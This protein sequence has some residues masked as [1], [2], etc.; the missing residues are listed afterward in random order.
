MKKLILLVCLISV[1]LI[2]FAQEE[3]KTYGPVPSIT[4]KTLDGETFDMGEISNDG[5]PI[6]I[7]FGPPGANHVSKNMM[8]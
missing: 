8:P 5:K 3:S 6:I 2:T 1:S 4:V 7:T